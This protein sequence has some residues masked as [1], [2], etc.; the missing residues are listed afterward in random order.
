V[1]NARA[2]FAAHAIVFKRELIRVRMDVQVRSEMAEG[3]ERQWRASQ[4]AIITRDVDLR[5][6]TDDYD[7][8]LTTTTTDQR[9]RAT[10]ISY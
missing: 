2:S 3:E 4:R 5:P 7:D 8:R 10:T 1:H 9:Q 6:A